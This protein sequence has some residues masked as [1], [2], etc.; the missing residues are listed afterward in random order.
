[1]DDVDALTLA[2]LAVRVGLLTPAQVSE[3]WDDSLADIETSRFPVE[4]TT[5]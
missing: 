4:A 1:M 3:G 5:R 2:D